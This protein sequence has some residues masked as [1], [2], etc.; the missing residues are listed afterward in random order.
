MLAFSVWKLSWVKGANNSF[1]STVRN[2][3]RIFSLYFSLGHLFAYRSRT[4]MFSIGFGIITFHTSG[5]ASKDLMWL[6]FCIIEVLRCLLS[7]ILSWFSISLITEPCSICYFIEPVLPLLTFNWISC[8]LWIVED[9]RVHPDIAATLWVLFHLLL[10]KEG[11][12]LCKFVSYIL[13]SPVFLL[14]LLSQLLLE[15]LWGFWTNNVVLSIRV[16]T[17]K[18]VQGDTKR[19]VVKVLLNVDNRLRL[20]ISHIDWQLLILRWIELI[21]LSLLFHLEPSSLYKLH[22]LPVAEYHWDKFNHLLFDHFVCF[23]VL[24]DHSYDCIILVYLCSQLPWEVVVALNWTV[25]LP[26]TERPVDFTF[27][28]TNLDVALSPSHFIE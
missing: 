12:L 18:L 2:S 16:V 14:F 19:K 23:Y 22:P 8:W 25:F 4:N 3:F 20:F 28:L 24:R 17:S 5:N 13:F 7:L 9:A 10:V 27:N 15:K 26:E 6:S 11:S 1:C 21:L